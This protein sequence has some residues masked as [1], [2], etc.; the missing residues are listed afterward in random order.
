MPS[1]A[2]LP[3]QGQDIF[4]F[5]FI[6]PFSHL[7]DSS[8]MQPILISL[9]RH[10]WLGHRPPAPITIEHHLHHSMRHDRRNQ[11]SRGC[12]ASLQQEPDRRSHYPFVAIILERGTCEKRRQVNAGVERL[13]HAKCCYQKG[14]PRPM[15]VPMPVP[16]PTLLHR[17]RETQATHTAPID[18]C[19]HQARTFNQQLVLLCMR[20]GSAAHSNSSEMARHP[21][22]A[23]RASEK[24][25][26]ATEDARSTLFSSCRRLSCDEAR[27]QW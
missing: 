20:D 3:S 12:S 16:A 4:A 9:I 1:D 7:A 10:A 5:L 24:A 14:R 13:L 26:A 11:R 25:I 18:I 6:S 27:A 8:Q 19:S 17:T 23:I 22:R 21:S 2:D 15:P